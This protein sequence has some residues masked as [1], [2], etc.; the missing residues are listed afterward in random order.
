MNVLLLVAIGSSGW[1]SLYPP[2][3]RG[4]LQLGNFLRDIMGRLVM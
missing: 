1:T 2:G 3:E 4:G